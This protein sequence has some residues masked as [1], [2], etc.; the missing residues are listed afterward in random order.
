MFRL[1]L[2]IALEHIEV[3]ANPLDESFL[4]T[5]ELAESYHLHPATI[6][7]LFRN[8]DG[9]IRLGHGRLRIPY[10]VVQR[11]FARVTVGREA[12]TA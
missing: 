7:K 10:S 6:R 3:N 2:R 8:A 5:R 4:T 12:T 1:K 9:V 11:V